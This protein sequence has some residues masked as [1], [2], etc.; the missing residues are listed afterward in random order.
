V[1]IDVSDDAIKTAR[2][3]AEALSLSERV[4]F[5]VRS[6]DDDHHP[7]CAYDIVISNPPYISDEEMNGLAPEVALYDP[8]RALRG[9]A[10]GLNCYRS[11]I[12]KLPVFLKEKGYVFFEIGFAQAQAVRG[13]L[14]ESGY[15]VIETATDLGGHD[16]CI[17]AQAAS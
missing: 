4:E 2:E 13:L 10:D 3:N 14:E 16:R 15:T 9:G 5:F 17:I 12:K 11:I 8:A 6:W 7:S 1:G